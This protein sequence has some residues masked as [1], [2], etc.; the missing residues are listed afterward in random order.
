MSKYKAVKTMVGD[1]VFDSK[2]EAKRWVEL[3]KM[4]EDGK[5]KDLARQVKFPLL[6]KQMLDG[7]VIER[8][9]NYIADFIYRENGHLVVEDTKGIMTPEFRL[10]KK[11]MLYF[12]GIR[13]RIQ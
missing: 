2:K 10:K 7:K 11:M 9:C 13:I 8:Q 6:P 5:I 4:E 1:E 12:Y 3:R